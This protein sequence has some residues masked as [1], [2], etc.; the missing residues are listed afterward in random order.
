MTFSSKQIQQ[1]ARFGKI[2]AR[3]HLAIAIT[4]KY[5]ICSGHTDQTVRQVVAYKRLN[6]EENYKTVSL[7]T[8]SRSLTGGSRLQEVSTVRL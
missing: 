2:F 3:W 4:R 8:W 6:T 5:N 7:E 1:H